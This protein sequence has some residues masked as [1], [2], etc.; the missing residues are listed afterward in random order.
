M[1]DRDRVEVELQALLAL[2]NAIGSMAYTVSKGAWSVDGVRQEVER[3]EDWGP[4]AAGKA[5]AVANARQA[6]QFLKQSYTGL[7]ALQRELGLRGRLIS[8]VECQGQMSDDFA[9][10]AMPHTYTTRQANKE[11]LDD[12]SMVPGLTGAAASLVNAFFEAKDG[13]IKGA[14]INALGAIPGERLFGK[15]A[16]YADEVLRGVDGGSDLLRFTGETSSTAAGRLAHREWTE[17][18]KKSGKF[19]VV[20]QKMTDAAGN[21]IELPRRVN[22]KT[23]KPRKGTR[24]QTVQPDAVNFDEGLIVDLKPVGRRISKDRQQMIRYI[25]AFEIRTGRLPKT[26]QI[27]RY[28]A[29]GKVVDTETYTPGD[30]LP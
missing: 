10:A 29:F 28:D 7:Q 27:K 17:A 13:H 4:A 16:K 26:I 24:T 19:D 1:S 18:A 15:G 2:V 22:L 12:M 9:K 14:L 6:S 8:Q 3:L 11:F 5:Q 23:G 20:E 21:V 30:F 25:K